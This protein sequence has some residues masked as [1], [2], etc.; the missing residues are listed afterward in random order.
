M[1]GSKSERIRLLAHGVVFWMSARIRSG[2]RSRWR[3]YSFDLPRYFRREMG[4]N[5]AGIVAATA[6]YREVGDM[7]AALVWFLIGAAAMTVVAVT[8]G[9]N[10]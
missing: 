7:P 4:N 6:R 5:E 1:K 10:R 9:A 3:A 2:G 8:A